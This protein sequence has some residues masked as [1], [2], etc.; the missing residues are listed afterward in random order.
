MAPGDRNGATLIARIDYLYLGPSSGGAGGSFG[1]RRTRSTE[2]SW[3]KD[4]EAALPRTCRCGRSRLITRWRSIRRWARGPAR[5]RDGACAGFCRVG[6]EGAGSLD[7]S[8]G[9]G[10][11]VFEAR[12]FA[13]DDPFY[14]L[15]R[16]GRGE[17]DKMVASA[18][19]AEARLPRLAHSAFTL[20]GA[21]SGALAQSGPRFSN[22]SGQR[23]AAS[24][25]RRRS[26]RSLDGS[27]AQAGIASGSRAVSRAGRPKRC[28]PRGPDRLC[29]S[30][31]E[32]R[33]A[34][35]AGASQDTIQERFAFF[36]PRGGIASE[37]PLRAIAS[38]YSIAVDQAMVEQA[39]YWRTVA[40]AK[41]FAGWAPR[42]LGL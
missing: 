29:L 30:R 31:P 1:K 35:P 28:C 20:T 14:A 12:G 42:Q 17:K 39:Y 40:L 4:R 2:R 13:S 32:Q 38:Y 5:P 9:E 24:R 34:G 21:P 37:I 27:G 23:R 18:R 26:N 16:V 15:Y 11:C 10:G 8:V 19:L 33:G 41:V 36:G 7:M 22:I 25:A 3:L 6:A